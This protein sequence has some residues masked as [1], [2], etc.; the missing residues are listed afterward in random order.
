VAHNP[1]DRVPDPFHQ[2]A[3]EL[4]IV[5]GVLNDY[6]RDSD[7]DLDG[8][9]AHADWVHESSLA[10]EHLDRPVAHVELLI[11]NAIVS[12][13][14]HMMG[15][16]ACI[17]AERVVLAT[18]SLMRPAVV[19]AGIGHHLLE[20]NLHVR[21]RLRR[22]FNLELASVSEQLNGVDRAANHNGWLALSETQD[23]YLAWATNQGYRPKSKTRG[24]YLQPVWKLTD[25]E[26]DD[27]APNEVIL[28]SS[29]LGALGPQFGHA[30]YR[31]T[32]AF[33]HAQPHALTLLADAPD[34][35][36]PQTPGSV[37]RGVS[38]ADIATWVSVVTMAVHAAAGRAA[39]YFG[40]D[41]DG[42]IH[43]VDPIMTNWAALAN[44]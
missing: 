22:G 33:V 6:M 2:M 19:A 30:A 8:T 9:P 31:F 36:D 13:M 4:R 29:V 24:K 28:A 38:S 26:H 15:I 42:W 1:A 16:A 35:C 40:W 39:E 44:A 20:P 41:F 21:E 3:G 10:D 25:A 14:D 18:M 7:P 37:P 17:E 43:V 34:Q 11:L 12:S 5:A 27:G 23:R 32:S